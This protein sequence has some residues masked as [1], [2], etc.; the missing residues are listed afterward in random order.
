MDEW[1]I[2]EGFGERYIVSTRGEI[3]NAKSEKVLKPSVSP[4]GYLFCRLC[5]PN[6]PPKNMFVHRAVAETFIANPKNKTQVN[7][8]D[9]NKANNSVN[10]LEWVTPSENTLHSFRV[11]GRAGSLKEKFGKSNGNSRPV[12]QYDLN[13]NFVQSWDAVSDAARAIGCSP[14]QI[15][16]QMAGRIVTCHGFLWSYEKDDHMDNSRVK[17]RKTHK[18]WG[19]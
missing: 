3:K 5:R 15:I 14:C 7:H 17:G 19:L 4:T 18:R 10:N 16:N 13:G 12:Y 1:A 11:L 2:I 9:G 6:L 8:K